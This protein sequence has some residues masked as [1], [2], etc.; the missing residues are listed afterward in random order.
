MVTQTDRKGP[1]SGEVK[2][3]QWI[4]GHVNCKF[5]S[6]LLLSELPLFWFATIMWTRA[7]DTSCQ[8]THYLLFSLPGLRKLYYCCYNS[9][10]ICLCVEPYTK[11]FCNYLLKYI[12]MFY[13][14]LNTHIKCF[15]KSFE[16]VTYNYKKV[17]TISV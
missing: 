10:N 16:K 9:F 4:W 15:L 1:L 3:S 6:F 17:I 12:I 8:I 13:S 11:M 5:C 2:T 14:H 7:N